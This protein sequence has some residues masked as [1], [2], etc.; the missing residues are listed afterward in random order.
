MRFIKFIIVLTLVS[1]LVQCKRSDTPLSWDADYSLPLIHGSLGMA[2]LIPDSLVALGTDSSIIL[3]YEG[4]LLNVDLSEILTLPDTVILDTFQAPFPTPINVSPGQVFIS[5]P[6]E[7]ELQLSGISLSSVKIESGT[8][9]YVLEST[10]KGIVKYT[11]E[12]PSA[13]DATGNIFSKTI[14][15]PAASAGNTSTVSGTFSLDGYNMDLK[16]QSGQD[17]NKI[18]TNINCKVA[19]SNPT[20]VSISSADIITASNEF[21]DILIEEAEGYFGQHQHSTGLDYSAFDGFNN[22]ISGAID[23]DDLDVDLVIKNGVGIDLFMTLNQLVA[24]GNNSSVSLIHSMISDLISL[25]RPTRYYDSIVPTTYT[26]HLD[27]LNSNIDEFFEALPSEIGYD[28]DIEVNPMGNVS[29]YNDFYRSNAPIGVFINAS[30]PLSLIANDLTL[31][32]TITL[33]LDEA[34]ELNK[35]VL[36]IDVENGFPIQAD[37]E[38]GILDVNDKIISRVFSPTIIENAKVD[39]NGVV[40]ETIS[41]NHEIVLNSKDVERLKANGKVVLTISFN[42]PGNQHLVIYDSYRLNFSVKADANITISDQN[43]N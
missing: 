19:L 11:Y 20:D 17:F 7:Q 26:T 22:W 3:T 41:S 40:T 14:T 13:T 29:G 8:V 43:E 1:F 24:V 16:G 21:K 10:V 18:M 25:P 28:L 4:N 2:D 27:P 30:M 31:E 37:I 34:G 36:Y 23:I 33:S 39:L 9:E 42:T 15:V 35:L 32:D 6:G 38:M 5:D 12:I